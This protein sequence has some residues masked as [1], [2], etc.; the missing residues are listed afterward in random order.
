MLDEI[1]Q[2]IGEPAS[3][4]QGPYVNLKRRDGRSLQKVAGDMDGIT[5]WRGCLVL[6]TGFDGQSQDITWRAFNQLLLS[7]NELT[8]SVRD[9]GGQVSVQTRAGMC[10]RTV[11]LSI[12]GRRRRGRPLYQ[13]WEN[14]RNQR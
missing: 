9:T 8:T 2:Y 5:M 14:H 11:Q 12:R 13:R 1:R 10:G 4:F 6:D 7:T 3:L